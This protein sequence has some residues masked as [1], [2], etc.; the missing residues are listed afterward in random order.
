MFDFDAVATSAAWISEI[1]QHDPHDEDD[2]D[3]DNDNHHHEHEHHH[4]EHEHEHEHHH[5]HHDHDEHDE[6]CESHHGGECT[7]GHHHHHHNEETGEAEE[8]GIGTYVYYARKPFDIIQ[9][10][11]F[12]ARKWP[13]NIIRA[14][15]LC[16]FADQSHLCYIFEQAGRQVKLENAGQWYA[17]MPEEELKQFRID[18]PGVNRD[19][20]DKYGDRMQKLVFIGQHLDKALIKK[21]LDSC[22]IE[23]NE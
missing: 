5:H 2:D 10:D 22:L 15:G 18:N 20:D 13:K 8:Y 7:C 4:H 19:W 6:H 14:K 3:N 9:F 1:E 16:W 17:T 21:E 12:V 11:D 23:W